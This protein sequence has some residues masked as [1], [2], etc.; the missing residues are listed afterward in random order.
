M[1]CS[2]S[3]A[4]LVVLFLLSSGLA[5][6]QEL[7]EEAR[8]LITAI[9]EARAQSGIPALFTNLALSQA[10]AMHSEEMCRLNYYSADSPTPG[11][12]K[13]RQRVN[14]KGAN[15]EHLNQQIL[16]L[17]GRKVNVVDQTY[18]SLMVST[19]KRELLSS[20]YTDIGIGIAAKGDSVRIT[21]VLGGG[22][23]DFAVVDKGAAVESA[24]MPVPALT[25]AI[26]EL[27]NR[28][29]ARGGVPPL[30]ED[31]QLDEAAQGHSEEMLRLNYFSHISPIEERKR[32]RNRVNLARSNPYRVAE[33]LYRCTGY[34]EDLIPGFSIKAWLESPGHRANL[35]DPRLNR[36]G[37]GVAR[38][39]GRYYI[40]Q[41]FSGDS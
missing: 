30:G 32:V 21:V 38:F 27:V 8:A 33:N 41:V 34:K 2:R 23:N 31:R 35:L 4:A 19:G 29:R 40:T 36:I 16:A 39:Q 9:N 13:V 18:R 7:A 5:T 3:L 12:E 26:I 22:S 37:V 28:E 24:P 10:A 1:G 20:S 11:L 6:A 25:Q 17:D 14:L 15:P